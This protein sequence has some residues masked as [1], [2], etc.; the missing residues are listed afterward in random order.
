MLSTYLLALILSLFNQ[1]DSQ[2]SKIYIAKIDWHV[3]IILKVDENLIKNISA[4]QYF[5]DFNYV[6]IGWGDAD[7]YQSPDNF[8][9]YLASKAIL[10]PTTSVIRIQGYNQSIDQII[11]WREYAFEVGLLKDEYENL[12]KFIDNS[13]SRDSTNNL[14]VT[15]QKNNKR[16]T[17]FSSVHKY[18]LFNT[19]NTWVADA[20]DFAGQD[21]NASDVV[22][23][24]ELYF[25]LLKFGKLVKSHIKN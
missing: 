5:K 18:H 9:L 7:F 17:F 16:V 6:D 23:A 3:G 8:D 10:F 15:L 12:C 19:C 20:L 1:F 22:T 24:D 13:F 14:S 2:A 21:I 4:A 25:E 11:N